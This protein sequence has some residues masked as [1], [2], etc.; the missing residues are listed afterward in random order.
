MATLLT[1]PTR[2]RQRELAHI[3]L[4]VDLSQSLLN[5]MPSHL[6]GT[7]TES[8][9]LDRRDALRAEYVRLLEE[10]TGQSADKIRERLG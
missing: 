2:D 6:L 3:G 7:E 9:A 10:M 1:F 4:A 5:E 8:I